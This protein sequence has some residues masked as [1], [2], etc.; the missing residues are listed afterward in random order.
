[1]TASHEGGPLWMTAAH[2]RCLL[3]MT[4]EGCPP[5]VTASHDRCLL[6]MTG[7]QEGYPLWMSAAWQQW[8]LAPQDTQG[9]QSTEASQVLSYSATLRHHTYRASC[10]ACM[11]FHNL[12]STLQQYI[13]AVLVRVSSTGEG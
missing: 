8:A 10:S 6:L 11:T 2:D 3:F 4:Q 9:S 12:Q 1:M 13:S 5:W 7:A